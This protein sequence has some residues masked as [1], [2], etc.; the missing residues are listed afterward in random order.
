MGS[1]VLGWF[2]EGNKKICRVVLLLILLIV[3]TSGL[4]NGKEQGGEP[5]PLLRFG[6]TARVWGMGNAGVATAE[7]VEGLYYNPAALA[8]VEHPQLSISHSTMFVD[9]SMNFIATALPMGKHGGLG[10]GLL[11]LSSP[12][13]PKTDY[14]LVTESVIGYFDYLQAIAYWGMGMEL[15][16]GIGAGVT[17]KGLFGTLDDATCRG[18]S[19]EGGV[20]YRAS[21]GVTLGLLARDALGELSWSTGHKEDLPCQVLGGVAV[22]LLGGRLLVS[23]ET[24]TSLKE[25]GLGAEYNLRDSVQLRGGYVKDSFTAGAGLYLGRVQLDYAWVGHELGGTHRLSFSVGF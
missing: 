16:G 12:G 5:M 2:L 4:V 17:M 7:G 25:W 21:Q 8:S 19:L 11:I 6:T 20:R 13:I 24:D 18:Y 22:E 15:E 23:G 3:G 1:R 14:D 10:A 9:T